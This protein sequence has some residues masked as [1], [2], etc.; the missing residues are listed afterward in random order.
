MVKRTL[1]LVSGLV[2]VLIV[3]AGLLQFNLVPFPVGAFVV[4]M[5]GLAIAMLAIVLWAS[6]IGMMTKVVKRKDI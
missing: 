3:L 1:L 4:A 2:M 6:V 5:I